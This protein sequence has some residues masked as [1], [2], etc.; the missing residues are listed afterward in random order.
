MEVTSR[1]YFGV[2]SDRSLI[3]QAVVGLIAAVAWA[4]APSGCFADWD[5]ESN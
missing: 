5:V 4:G 2:A 3:E 1:R